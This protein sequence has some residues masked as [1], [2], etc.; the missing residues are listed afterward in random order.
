M[1]NLINQRIIWFILST[2]ST[3]IVWLSIFNLNNNPYDLFFNHIQ[4]LVSI[5][6]YLS[7]IFVSVSYSPPKKP[8]FL[9]E[10]VIR[11]KGLLH[12]LAV[13]GWFLC[14][15]RTIM[16]LSQ[17]SFRHCTIQNN[18]YSESKFHMPI[19]SVLSLAYEAELES[20]QR[21]G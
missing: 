20:D 1:C 2:L 19:T 6:W 12:L 18:C 13:I 16:L 7:F 17:I 4:L 15:Q 11:D 3:Q 14:F 8:K 5:F 21:Q 9:V 10:K